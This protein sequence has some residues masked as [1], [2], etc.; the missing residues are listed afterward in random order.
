MTTV[1][2]KAALLVLQ[3]NCDGYD[4]MADDEQIAFNH[5]TCDM[6]ED[7]KQRL[8]VKKSNGAYLW[9]CHNCSMS[10]YYRDNKLESIAYIDSKPSIHTRAAATYSAFHGAEKDFNKFPLEQQLWLLQYDFDETRCTW[11]NIRSSDEGVYIPILDSVGNLSGYQIRLFGKKQ[12]YFTNT[13]L[14]YSHL[15]RDLGTLILT[16]DLLSAYKLYNVGYA[17]MA[18]LGT[19]LHD[20]VVDAIVRC[21]YKEVIVWLD[22]DIAGHKGGKEILKYLQPIVKLVRYHSA[23]QAKEIPIDRLKE[24]NL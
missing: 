1:Y 11:N 10:G 24:L 9:H 14:P 18:L 6:G 7:T 13:S 20:G 5:T 17:T 8:Y 23:P 16:E 12:K 15:H 2:G 4:E 19:S 3:D 22:D 21:K